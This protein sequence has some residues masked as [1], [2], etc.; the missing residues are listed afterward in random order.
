MG[1]VG[2]HQPAQNAQLGRAA[3]AARRF[4]YARCCELR[5]GGRAV[6]ERLGVCPPNSRDDRFGVPLEEDTPQRTGGKA[7]GASNDG[8]R[9]ATAA[10]V[11]A[12][13]ANWCAIR[14]ARSRDSRRLARAVSVS[15]RRAMMTMNTGGHVGP[16]NTG[17]CGG[18]PNTPH[19]SERAR[20][21]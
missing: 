9:R 10:L 11:D 19:G 20:P 5:R 15:M 3:F 17:Q 2:N 16:G 21:R 8:L 13:V 6:R 1:S 12:S 7:D 18:E 14:T 4:S